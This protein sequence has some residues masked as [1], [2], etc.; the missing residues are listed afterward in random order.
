MIVHTPGPWSVDANF[1]Y[2]S[3]VKGKDIALIHLMS[4]S[5]EENKA[6]ARLMAAA[7]EL[8]EA[9]RHTLREFE[10]WATLNKDSVALIRDTI[11]KA[12]NI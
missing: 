5:I 11:A 10:K 8:L 3:P 12:T 7:P 4:G 6:N 9:C 2:I 1:E